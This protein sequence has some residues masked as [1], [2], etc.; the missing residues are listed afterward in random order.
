V[1]SFSFKVIDTARDRERVVGYEVDTE[2]RGRRSAGKGRDT[3]D[4]VGLELGCPMRFPGC[5]VAGEYYELL[6]ES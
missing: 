4:E 1:L 6:V 5:R 3:G 2:R